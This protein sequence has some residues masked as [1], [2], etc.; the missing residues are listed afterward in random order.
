MILD[1]LQPERILLQ[2]TAR[3]KRGVL[4]ELTH[5][6][7]ADVAQQERILGGLAER[8]KVMSTGIGKGIA[9]PHARLESAGGLD[10]ALVRYPR[11]IDFEALDGQP[12]YLA[13]GVIGPPS[14]TGEHV[15]LLA[16]IARL[17]KEQGA[18]D[19]LLAAGSV[20]DV[21]AVLERR[22]R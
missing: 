4:R 21:L 2:G 8:E 15:K 12:V 9:I 6:L 7:S 1:H 17:V 10:L 14:G 20:E 3:D 13:F 16:R 19:D 22:D 5:L 18:L 11:G